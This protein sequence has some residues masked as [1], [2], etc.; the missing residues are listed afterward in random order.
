MT[1]FCTEGVCCDS[2]CTSTCWT[3]A[4]QGN[5]GSC[6]PADTG[7]DPRNQCPEDGV[8]S[9]GRDGACDG[10]GACRRYPTWL[11]RL[12]L[13]RKLRP[14]NVIATGTRGLARAG[15]GRWYSTAAAAARNRTA[16]QVG[17]T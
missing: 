14:G 16:Q 6:I 5:V 15:S 10:S 8:A 1:G 9:C 13:G 3:C 7:T 17:P 12:S 11:K 2:A 4:A